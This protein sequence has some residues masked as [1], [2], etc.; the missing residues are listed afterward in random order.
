MKAIL[1]GII[2]GAVIAAFLCRLAEED[3]RRYI[4]DHMRSVELRWHLEMANLR[5]WP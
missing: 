4:A 2:T 5:C 1:S 3:Q